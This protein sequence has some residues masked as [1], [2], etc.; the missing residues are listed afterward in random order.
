M[1]TLY[2]FESDQASYW[3]AWEDDGEII[4]H[5]G[6][7]GERGETRIIAL[8][9]GHSAKKFIAQEAKKYRA[10]GYRELREDEEVTLLVQYRLDNWGT[11]EDLDIRHTVENLLNE[12]LGWTGNGK[13]DGGD[14]GS[15][16]MNV[17]S[18]V[19][20][21]YLA[22]Q[23]IVEELRKNNFLEGVVIAIERE[24]SFKVLYPEN[25]DKEFAYWY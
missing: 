16:T 22:A 10:D 11:S 3:E 8:Q 19:V 20:N 1:E 7:L 9:R 12:C 15:G 18:I 6:Q 5:W 24:D 4:I 25:Y 17:C 14:I 23:T 21:P 2:K 13:C